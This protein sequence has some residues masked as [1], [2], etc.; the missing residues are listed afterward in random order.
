MT[1]LI[2]IRKMQAELMSKGNF[3]IDQNSIGAEVEQ[4]LPA[5]RH[6]SQPESMSIFY[7]VIIMSVI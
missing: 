3:L 1:E 6:F 5:S 2:N 7:K 4:S